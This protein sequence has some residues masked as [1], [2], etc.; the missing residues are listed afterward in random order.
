MVAGEYAEPAGVDREA[1]IEP[2]LGGEVRD[3][4]VL[5]PLCPGP[6]C[7]GAAVADE[8]PLHALEA[9]EVLGRQR[10]LELRIGQLGEERGR[11]R[12]ELGEASRFEVHEEPPRLGDP[13]EREVA[14][15]RGQR[16]TQ[17]RAVLYFPPNVLHGAAP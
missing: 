13:R 4:E 17:R 16:G 2:E 3:E 1:L 11:V 8:S 5:G 6:P 7:L 10:A 12:V 15:D 14:R 9:R